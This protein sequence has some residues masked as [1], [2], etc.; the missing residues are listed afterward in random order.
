ML[1]RRVSL[2]LSLQVMASL[3]NLAIAILRLRGARNIAAALRPVIIER[4]SARMVVDGSGGVAALG[5]SQRRFGGRCLVSARPMIAAF[6]SWLSSRLASRRLGTM[7]NM[8][9]RRAGPAL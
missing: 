5:Y 6:S 9:G 3:R 4:Y 1:Y 7:G 8:P 2:S